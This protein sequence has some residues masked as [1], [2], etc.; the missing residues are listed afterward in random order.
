MQLDIMD[1]L[2]TPGKAIERPIEIEPAVLDDVEFVEPVRG[3][4]RVRNGRQSIVVS[5]RAK[6]PV[7][8]RCA[9][10]L[11]DFTQTLEIELEAMAPL[12]FFAAQTAGLPASGSQS[13]E[14]EDTEADD[15]LV[16]V[17]EAHHV[18]V[19]ELVRQA[20][21]LQ[22]PIQPLCR[23]DCPGLPQAVQY[24]SGARDERWSALGD[25]NANSK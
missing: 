25:W 18:N 20:A 17:F 2:R 7:R 13:D 9:R 10:C 12:S 6:A 19:L 8:L 1:V 23:P 4:V 15:E 24:Q 21:L 22:I 5:G 14:S 16:G 11:C 3:V